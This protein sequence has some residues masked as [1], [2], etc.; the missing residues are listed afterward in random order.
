VSV[1]S[2]ENSLDK[3][4]GAKSPFIPSLHLFTPSSSLIFEE[5][6]STKS[7]S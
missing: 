1:G 4:L 7:Q 6:G 5:S 3:L 2:H